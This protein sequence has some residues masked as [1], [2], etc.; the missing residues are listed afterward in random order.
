[1]AKSGWCKFPQLVVPAPGEV[2]VGF[3]ATCRCGKR[4][5]VTVRGLFAHHKRN[6]RPA[7]SMNKPPSVTVTPE[8]QDAG[9]RVLVGSG[10]A[11]DYLEADKLLLADIYRA[12]HAAARTAATT[13]QTPG[14]PE[15]RSVPSELPDRQQTCSVCGAG[16]FPIH[17][18]HPNSILGGCAVHSCPIDPETGYPKSARDLTHETARDRPVLRIAMSR[19]GRQSAQAWNE[20]DAATRNRR[21]S[22][23]AVR[24][25]R[26]GR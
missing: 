4:V 19:R 6:H 18:V 20:R 24:V 5:S 2:G 9:F 21:L 7:S 17:G 16:P 3:K 23:W 10:I 11:D 1:M 8:M 22:D 25:G 12:M 26:R 13:S 15:N 14:A